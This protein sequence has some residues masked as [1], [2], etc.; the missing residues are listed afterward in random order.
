MVYS[1][2][3]TGKQIHERFFEKIFFGIKNGKHIEMNCVSCEV[4]LLICRDV[5]I[6][7]FKKLNFLS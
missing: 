1:Q 2:T 3:S 5:K 6:F 4:F 7:T